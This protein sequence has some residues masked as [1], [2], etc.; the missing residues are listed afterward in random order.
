MKTSTQVILFALAW[1]TLAAVVGG[2]VGNM[3]VAMDRCAPAD[4]RETTVNVTNAGQPALNSKT[5][6]R[7]VILPIRS[8]QSVGGNKAYE[9]RPR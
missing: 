1:A 6:D 7:Y 5:D 9:W 2:T 4:A 3:V 8:P